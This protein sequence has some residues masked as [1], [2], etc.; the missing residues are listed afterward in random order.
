M[1]LDCPAIVGT[2]GTTGAV[3]CHDGAGAVVAWVSVPAFD[4]ASLDTTSLAG[5]FGAGFTV[6]FLGW[7]A[8]RG[9]TLVLS[10]I[11]SL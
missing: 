3:T 1:Q 9:A 7:A 11:K 6:C 10:M 4:I 5:A 2:D 8:G